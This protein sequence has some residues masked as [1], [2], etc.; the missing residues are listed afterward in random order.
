M[1]TQSFWQVVHSAAPGLSFRSAAVLDAIL[2]NGDGIG[3]ETQLAARLGL[4]NRW[5]F[6]R[7][8]ERE[9]LPPLRE[10]VAWGRVL[11]WIGEHERTNEGLCAIAI[12]R[13]LDPGDCYR[14]VQRTAGVPWHQLQ[15][16]GFEWCVEKFCGRLRHVHVD[17]LGKRAL[18]TP[19]KLDRG[20]SVRLELLRCLLVMSAVGFLPQLA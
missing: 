11:K 20:L 8:L 15:S 9:C 17:R 6:S 18:A 5:Q 7:M 10:L 19:I 3:T 13:G 4:H 12:R 14:V 16:L 2:L 1:D